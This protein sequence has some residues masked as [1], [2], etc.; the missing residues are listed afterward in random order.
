MLTFLES[1]SQLNAG[2]NIHVCYKMILK[3]CCWV[4]CTGTNGV[5]FATINPRI[6]QWIKLSFIQNCTKFDSAE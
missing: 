1:A 2:R 3:V 4:L 5:D 6:S